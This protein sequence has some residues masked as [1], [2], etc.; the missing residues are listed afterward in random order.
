MVAQR[1]DDHELIVVIEFILLF[2]CLSILKWTITYTTA[3][4]IFAS[5]VIF[6]STNSLEGPTMSLLSRS[7][8]Q[9]YRRGFWNVGLL[10]TESGTLGRAVGDV[11]LTMC[12]SAGLQ[13]V[14]NYA[15]GAMAVLSTI[16]IMLTLRFYADMDAHEK[17]E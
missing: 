3:Q 17:N 6:I 9:C 15:F 10:A 14:L 16:T 5:I 12:G 8:P 13:Y 7:I 11:I 2:G 4:Y 1:Y